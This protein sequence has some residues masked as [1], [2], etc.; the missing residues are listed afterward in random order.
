M[1]T[2]LTP[3]EP[4]SSTRFVPRAASNAWAT[5]AA[6][7]ALA[8]LL[9]SVFA[10]GGAAD[11]QG[12][13]EGTA[14]D[15]RPTTIVVHPFEGSQLLLGTALADRVAVALAQ[16]E[17]PTEVYGP[18]VAPVL[19]P[20]TPVVGGFVN[21]GALLNE[22]S[23]GSP[24]GLDL[25]RGGTGADL[26]VGGT[27]TVGDDRIEVE[28]RLHDAERLVRG[29]FVAS[30][31]APHRAAA[32]IA[33]WIAYR[34]D[35]GDVPAPESFVLSGAYGDY[36]RAVSLASA[37]LVDDA[38]AAL[39]S[40]ADDAGLDDAGATL[41]ADL[42]ALAAGGAGSDPARM[43]ALALAAGR[44]DETTAGAYVDA[45]AA[46]AALPVGRLWDAVLAVSVN[47][48]AGSED[49][50]APIARDAAYPY[51]TLSRAGARLRRTAEGASGDLAWVDEAVDAGGAD[52]AT[53]IGRA[54]LAQSTNDLE[55]EIAALT[56]LRS[57]TPFLPYP[58]E[59]LSFLAFDRDDALA[60][61][62]ALAVA[63]ELA[64]D[65]DL[66]WTNYGWALYLLGFVE[67][68]EAASRRAIAL[69]GSQ[70]IARFNLGLSLVVRGSLNEAM[71]AYN[72]ATRLDPDVDDEAIVDLENALE[73]YPNEPAIHFALGNLYE[74]EGRRSEAATQ[75]EL[76]LE[77]SSE[78]ERG[79]EASRRAEALRQPPPPIE[80]ASGLELEIGGTE[81]EG[82]AHPGDPLTAVFELVTPGRSLPTRVTA[83]ASLRDADGEEVVSGE[84]SVDVPEGAIGYVVDTLRIEVPQGLINGTYTLEISVTAPGDLEARTEREIEVSGEAIVTR[85]LIGRGVE[86]RSLEGD[87]LTGAA[88]LGG[89][90][91]LVAQLVQELQDTADAAEEALPSAS[92]GRFDGLSG[93]EIF[94]ASSEDD[95]RD[96]LAFL[97]EQGVRDA[98]LTF[99]DAYAQ[100][101]LDGVAGD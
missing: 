41:L 3:Q 64:P 49:A 60:A 45:F 61:A 6:R 39:Q 7:L 59:R 36:V 99:V 72:A 77:R 9:A 12:D 40:G 33:H 15:A 47:D 11:A 38:R 28:V 69:D 57:A 35:L 95:V 67:R 24:S 91:R 88:D 46:A 25:L 37:G 86:L 83:V 87:I 29:T 75:F 42:D 27:V 80:I 48:L 78:L 34:L 53:L 90:N 84:R 66:Y 10:L 101:A 4:A 14:H 58:F 68:S 55:A 31:E 97:V 100:W 2:P 51:A 74:I 19:L 20:P 62:E 18:L 23:L 43:V 76:Y 94:R 65:S 26:A 54:L 96:F 98:T 85:Q 81:L 82:S 16:A 93:G 79:A 5:R 22:R 44:F 1:L 32:G 50:Y 63:V 71:E 52:A 8:L 70:Y 21:P 30:S 56:E 89:A 13:A 17:R 92:G 73:L